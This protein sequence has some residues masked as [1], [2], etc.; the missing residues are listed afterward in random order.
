[1][2][3]YNVGSYMQMLDAT[4]AVDPNWI[5]QIDSADGT[6]RTCIP[7]S[8]YQWADYEAW[9]SSGNTALPWAPV[10]FPATS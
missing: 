9:L 1:M 5:C 10:S 2:T 8:G 6:A 4:G 7:S 3:T